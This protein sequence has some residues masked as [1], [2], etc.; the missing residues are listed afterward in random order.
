MHENFSTFLPS[1]VLI[2]L[3]SIVIIVWALLDVWFIYVA[4]ID[5]LIYPSSIFFA[6]NSYESTA[7]LVK[8]YTYIPPCLLSLTFNPP[9]GFI[10]SFFCNK[11]YTFSLYISNI[12]NYTSN[13]FAGSELLFILENISLHAIGTI[14]RFFPYPTIE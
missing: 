13:L 11:S 7:C 5:L 10:F 14:P 1:S 8:S 9:A 4:P 3:N 12:V 6:I 2:Y